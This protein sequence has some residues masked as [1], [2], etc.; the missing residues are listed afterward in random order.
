MKSTY[1]CEIK[2]VDDDLLRQ[3][4]MKLLST[5]LILTMCLGMTKPIAAQE[6]RHVVMFQFKENALKQKGAAH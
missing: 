4:I 5:I 2:H 6:Y 1:S 3:K